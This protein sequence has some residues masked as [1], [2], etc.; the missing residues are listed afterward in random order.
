MSN[1][2]SAP[3]AARLL[4]A[5]IAVCLAFAA[6][7]G[8]PVAGASPLSAKRAEADRV[9]AQVHEFDAKL[10]TAVERYDAARAKL[11]D[12]RA[13]IERNSQ[14]LVIA[15][16]NLVAARANLAKAL[17]SSYKDGGGSSTAL[18]VLGAESFS[19]LVS[20][21]DYVDRLSTTQ[22][23]L[24]SEVAKAQ[25]DVESRQRALRR[26]EKRSE[27]L[28]RDSRQ[29]KKEIEAGLRERQRLLAG[30]KSDIAQIIAA[31]ER[32]RERAA[33]A[34]A[35][36]AAQTQAAAATPS[37]SAPGPGTSG[38]GGGG[39]G[40]WVPPAGGLGQQAA[41]VAMRYL[42]VPYVYGGSSPSGFDCSGL[43]AYA[44]GQVGVSLPHYTGAL[45]GAGPHVSRDQLAV[46]DLVFFD[47]LGHVGI[48]VG[49]G[50]FVHAPH[51]GDVVKVSSLSDSWYAST[52]VGAVRITG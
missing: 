4:A 1:R 37:T 43:V 26:D 14:L 51:T 29:Q 48:Y 49:G 11:G 18:Y 24:L 35:A 45:W 13:A 15:R 39:G 21:M 27:Q 6:A 9:A 10:S 31:Q 25:R 36:Q 38:G 20:R 16:Q 30:I 12:V 41:A 17:V 28:V 19:E 33:L 40:A 44:Y 5:L 32:A 46:G 2:R 23:A 47:G 3:G 34:A 42:G 8:A 52:Y 7:V 22:N 50:S